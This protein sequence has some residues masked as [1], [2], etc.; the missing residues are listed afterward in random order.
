MRPFDTD[1]LQPQ[2]GPNSSAM[3]LPVQVPVA[4]SHPDFPAFT[5]CLAHQQPEDQMSPLGLVCPRCKQRLY[6]DPPRGRCQSYWESQPAAYTLDRQPCFVYTLVWSDFRIRSLHAAHSDS[7]L[8]GS[9][10][11]LTEDC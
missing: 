1:R 8:R 6:V 5:Q 4:L 7:D 2:V 11:A 10:A 3:E 9:L